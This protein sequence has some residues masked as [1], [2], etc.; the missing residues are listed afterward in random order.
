MGNFGALTLKVYNQSLVLQ[1]TYTNVIDSSGTAALNRVGNGEC[2]VKVQATQTGLTRGN[3]AVVYVADAIGGVD[4]SVAK[5]TIEEIHYKT[6]PDGM[7]EIRMS[8][9]D[10]LGEL[11]GYK[12]F[13]DIGGV[14]ASNIG[15]GMAMS[16][17]YF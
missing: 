9:R 12:H 3:I 17:L 4:L 2:T 6:S 1:A 7:S 10:L 11:T 13:V 15:E 16:V 14:Y 8:G 5:F